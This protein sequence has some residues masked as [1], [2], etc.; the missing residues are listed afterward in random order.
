MAVFAVDAKKNLEQLATWLG[1]IAPRLVDILSSVLG[2]DYSASLDR[3]G[4]STESAVPTIQIQSPS[5]LS[6]EVQ[7]LVRSQIKQIYE[8]NG[9]ANLP[10]HFSQDRLKLLK[11]TREYGANSVS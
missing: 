2:P 8:H 10:V 3:L 9:R 11:N 4:T 7:A 5:K 1:Y 6:E